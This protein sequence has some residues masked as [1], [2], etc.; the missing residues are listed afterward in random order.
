MKLREALEASG[1]EIARLEFESGLC[2]YV[3]ANEGG[4]MYTVSSK[5]KGIP[6][7]PGTKSK[8]V[9]GRE[10]AITMMGPHAQLDSWEPL[11]RREEA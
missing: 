3:W 2:F 10:A 6:G 4:E 1:Y 7:L 8:V 11:P 9:E 5:V